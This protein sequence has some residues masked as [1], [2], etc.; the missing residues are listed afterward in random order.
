MTQPVGFAVQ[1]SS[2]NVAAAAAVATLAGAAGRTT[3]ISGFEV[4]GAGA[5]G[6]AV[7]TVV[8]SGILGGSL[9]YVLAIPAGATLQVTPL[10]VE[11]APSL[12]ASAQNTA[13]VVTAASFGAG[14]TNAATVAHGFQL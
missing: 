1:N 8:V 14:N 9:T 2:G 12:P 5:T 4:T 11:F 10:I 6:A 3:Y 7:V 13:I